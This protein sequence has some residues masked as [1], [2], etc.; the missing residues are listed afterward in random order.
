MKRKAGESMKYPI[1][2]REA[3]ALLSANGAEAY[4]VGGCLRNML[5]GKQ[6]HDWDMTTSALPCL[7][8]HCFSP[9]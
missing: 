2:V 6:P 4:I 8:T 5:M 9:L 7:L 1:E 3:M